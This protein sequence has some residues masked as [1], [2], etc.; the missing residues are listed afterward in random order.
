MSSA[1]ARSARTIRDSRPGLVNAAY[2]LPENAVNATT[3][4]TPVK[5]QTTTNTLNGNLSRLATTVDCSGHFLNPHDMTQTSVL[6][7][8]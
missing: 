7:R 8:K 2:T 4:G 6:S 1:P 3:P 5:A